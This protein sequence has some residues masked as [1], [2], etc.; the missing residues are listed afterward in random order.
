MRLLIVFSVLATAQLAA[1]TPRICQWENI[2]LTENID[3]TTLKAYYEKLKN[4]CQYTLE[5]DKV[6]DKLALAGRPIENTNYYQGLR[7]VDRYSY[8][9]ARKENVPLDVVF[10]IKKED[11]AVPVDLRS[12]LVWNNWTAGINTL[13]SVKATLLSGQP[14]TLKMLSSIHKSFY[15]ADESGE[16]GKVF[17]PGV[18]K[19][20]DIGEISWPITQKLEETT[21]NVN[22]INQTYVQLELQPEDHFDSASFPQILLV[23]NG[24]LAPSHPAYIYYHMKNFENFVNDM[25]QKA[26]MGKALTW[27]GQIFTP[28]EFAL[29]VQQ[30]VVRI[31]GFYDG[32]GRT[33]RYM[34][35]LILSLF[36]MPFLPSGDIQSEDMTSTLPAYYKQAGLACNYQIQQLNLCADKNYQNFDCQSINNANVRLNYDLAF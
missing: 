18:L 17:Y 7:Y 27:K 19:T 22:S 33:S 4:E 5:M 30:T 20:K 29:F 31:H 23:K 21:A 34:Q 32:N 14:F 1:A 35:D 24:T 3:A 11:Y 2:Q 25:I 9:K 15:T 12:H 16:Y 36:D 26:R 13:P 6:K 28:M 10:Q 8:E